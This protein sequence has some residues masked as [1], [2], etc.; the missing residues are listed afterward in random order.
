MGSTRGFSRRFGAAERRR[1]RRKKKRRAPPRPPRQ[2]EGVDASRAARRGRREQGEG[3]AGAATSGPRRQG[4][5]ARGR[6][7]DGEGGGVGRGE[8]RGAREYE[9]SVGCETA[10]TSS[11]GAATLPSHPG[12]SPA[13]ARR[14]DSGDN[15]PAL[16]LVT[17]VETA[18]SEAERAFRTLETR[19][20]DRAAAAASATANPHAREV[21]SLRPQ[22]DVEAA[23]LEARREEAAVAEAALATVQRADSA[24]GTRAT[25]STRARRAQRARVGEYMDALTGARSPW[26]F[27][28]PPSVNPTAG[29]RD[30][31]RRGRTA[32]SAGGADAED[33]DG[34]R[35]A[36]APPSPPPRRLKK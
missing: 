1:R 27:D 11:G 3:R 18:V 9:R 6:R 14:A 24:F 25:S 20:R 35:R 29:R 17:A 15:A 8:P 23:E 22:A 19:S 7:G 10:S 31:R 21:A 12:H 30:G 4:Q 32:R 16:A 28:P 13:A 33:E 2:R 36:P 26:S 5:R 34:G